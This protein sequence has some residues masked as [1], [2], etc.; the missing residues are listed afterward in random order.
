MFPI[1]VKFVLHD[2]QHISR[3]YMAS[4]NSYSLK[5]VGVSRLGLSGVGQCMVLIVFIN[6]YCI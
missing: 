1:V 2:V 6:Q 3:Y 4:I 5:D